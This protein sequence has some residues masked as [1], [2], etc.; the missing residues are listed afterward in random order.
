LFPLNHNFCSTGIGLLHYKL[1]RAVN[2]FRLLRI[3]G[4]WRIFKLA[5]KCAM[6]Y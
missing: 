6:S 3:I 1:G 5:H 4:R 2:D